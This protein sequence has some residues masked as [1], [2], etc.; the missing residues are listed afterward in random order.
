MRNTLS[1]CSIDGQMKRRLST[2]AFR[3]VPRTTMSAAASLLAELFRSSSRQLW[4][5]EWCGY[6][7]LPW[8]RWFGC[9]SGFCDCVIRGRFYLNQHLVFFVVTIINACSQKITALIRFNISR[10]GTYTNVFKYQLTIFP[11]P[12][13]IACEYWNFMTWWS[14]SAL[15]FWV[16]N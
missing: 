10:L 3:P 6:F 4:F 11:A 1:M 7:S 16:L 8:K 2:Y 9:L 5:L 15:V 12:W 13:L 14:P